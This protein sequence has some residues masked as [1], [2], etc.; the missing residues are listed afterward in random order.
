MIDLRS[1]IQPGDT[2]TW[3]QGTA[4]PLPLT[5]ELVRDR[6]AFKRVTCFVLTSFSDTLQPEHSDALTFAGLGPVGTSRALSRAV[7]FET[8]PILYSD[9]PRFI[10]TGTIPIDVVLVQVSPADDRGQ[11]S[12]GIIADCMQAAIASARVVLAEVNQ[13]MPHT[14]GDT[15]IDGTRFAARSR[16]TVPSSRYSTLTQARSSSS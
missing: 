11:H 5:N 16:P 12:L 2:V 3:G 1:Y 4:E 15:Q 10:A 7:G 13:Q 6:M 9:L 8:Y 14:R